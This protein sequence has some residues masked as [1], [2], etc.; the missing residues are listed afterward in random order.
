MQQDKKQR[1]WSCPHCGRSFKR[2][3]QQH[4]CGLVSKE[5]LFAKRPPALKVL[6]QMIRDYVTTLGPFHEEAHTP[7]IIY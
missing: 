3:N 1:M 4:S 6:Y 2:K 7:D 5:D